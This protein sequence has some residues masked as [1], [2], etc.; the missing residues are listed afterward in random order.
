MAEEE[1]RKVYQAEGIVH[2]GERIAFWKPKEVLSG[3]NVMF[4]GGY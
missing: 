3:W 2:E 1:V 4:E